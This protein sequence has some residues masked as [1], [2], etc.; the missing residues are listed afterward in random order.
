MN[1]SLRASKGHR[2]R[3]LA[4][5]LSAGLGCG[6]MA[7]NA[8]LVKQWA[9][10]GTVIPDGNAS[11]L[12]SA[13][14]LDDVPGSILDVNVTLDLK[15]VGNG[16]WNGDLYVLLSHGSHS[17]VLINRPGVTAANPFGYGD[18]GFRVTFDDDAAGDLHLYQTLLAESISRSP[19]E[20]SW[21][22]DARLVDPSSVLDTSPRTRFLS[23]FN[24]MSPAGE[25]RLF[26]A[27]LSL[28]GIVQLESW[29]L[30]ITTGSVPVPEGGHRGTL[31]AAALIAGALL[32]A[33]RRRS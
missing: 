9:I 18:S 6:A 28:G 31:A 27:D 14:T 1:T 30:E 12:V 24:G 23:G 29:G 22:P 4:I 7:G 8:D 15:G 19:L 21:Q 11:G 5:L 20:G 13:V 33:P 2:A 32:L 26:L 3:P 25:W 10:G 17:S 16:G